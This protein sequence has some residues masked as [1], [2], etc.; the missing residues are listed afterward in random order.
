MFFIVK[1]IKIEA[2][3]EKILFF[4]SLCFFN[5]FAQDFKVGDQE[6]LLMPIA[7][8]M[9]QEKNIR[10]GLFHL[11]NDPLETRNCYE[12]HP[13]IVKRLT[14]FVSITRP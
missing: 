12:Q 7:Y 8:T 11:E 14:R 1:C 3:D 5:G 6:L 10:G 13:E 4:L 2:C 9:P